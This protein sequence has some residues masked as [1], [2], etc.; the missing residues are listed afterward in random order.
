VISDSHIGTNTK[1][2]W[3]QKA[4]HEPYLAAVFDH[5]VAHATGVPN[6]VTKLVLLGDLFDFWTYPPD[7]RPPQGGQTLTRAIAHL[8]E[9]TLRAGCTAAD[10]PDQGSPYGLSLE[11]FASAL[12]AEPVGPSIT[13][14]LLDYF[15]KRCGLSESAP[16]IMADGAKTTLRQVKKK[17]SGLWDHWV[18]RY[19]GG[20]VGET[21]AAKAVKAD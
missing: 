20:E 12:L 19:G 7:Q 15:A 11:S 21:I 4:V 3:Y 13:S 1:T 18:S 14:L 6:P 10:L 17:Y 8:L 9:T 16:I 2:C 5:I